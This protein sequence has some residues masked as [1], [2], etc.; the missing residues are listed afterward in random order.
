[1]PVLSSSVSPVRMKSSSPV[2]EDLQE[3]EHVVAVEVTVE[4][5]AVTVV[6][7]EAEEVESPSSMPTTRTT[8]LLCEVEPTP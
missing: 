8:S 1:V 6:A 3:V 5:V 7:V 2:R 4:A